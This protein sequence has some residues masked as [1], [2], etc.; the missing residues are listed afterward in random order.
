MVQ[1]VFDALQQRF[2]STFCESFV[3]VFV[4]YRDISAS[5]K[6]L[7]N[8]SVII[9]MKNI[10]PISLLIFHLIQAFGTAKNCVNLI[11]K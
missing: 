3:V 10:I 11:T 7:N 4:T 2:R 9:S 8:I 6:A 5:L 1:N